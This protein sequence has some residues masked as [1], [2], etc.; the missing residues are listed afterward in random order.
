MAASVLYLRAASVPRGGVADDGPADGDPAAG[1][2]PLQQPRRD[3]DQP[4]PGQSRR[5]GTPP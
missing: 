2:E 1:G 4:G 3:Q 5:P